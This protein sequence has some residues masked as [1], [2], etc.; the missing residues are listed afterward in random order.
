MPDIFN[1]MYWRRVSS[2]AWGN[3]HIK[4]D[5]VDRIFFLSSDGVF[6]QTS[7]SPTTF[8]TDALTSRKRSSS[9]PQRNG[10]YRARLQGTSS[11]FPFT[12][13]ENSLLHRAFRTVEQ[14]PRG[15]SPCSIARHLQAVAGQYMAVHIFQPSLINSLK[16]DIYMVL[17]AQRCHCLLTNTI[18]FYLNAQ[19]TSLEAAMTRTHHIKVFIMRLGSMHIQRRTSILTY[20]VLKSKP[21]EMFLD[22]ANEWG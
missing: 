21:N 11:K 8:S 15:D 1:Q 19:A 13:E 20:N 10:T 5:F 4:S 14:S 17:G 2:K 16:I 12:Q 3:C 18:G 7:S 9:R 6:A 22:D